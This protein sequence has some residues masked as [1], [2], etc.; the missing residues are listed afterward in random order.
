MPEPIISPATG[1]SDPN[2]PNPVATPG[3]STT[4]VVTTFNDNC[5]ITDTVVINIGASGGVPGLWTWT[6]AINNNWFE[7][8]NWDKGIVPALTNDVLIPGGTP[9][10]PTITGATGFCK[11]LTINQSNGGHLYIDY[12]GSGHLLKQP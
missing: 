4:Y 6:G 1:L 9:N 7:P 2:I 8:C 12:A 5:T 11:L 10:N 3:S